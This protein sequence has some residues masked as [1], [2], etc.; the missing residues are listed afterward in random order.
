MK[1][2]IG[3]LTQK[4][5]FIVVFGLYYQLNGFLPH[6]LCYFIDS[7]GKQL[8]HIRLFITSGCSQPDYFFEV[9]QKIL[10]MVAL[11]PAGVCTRMTGWAQWF[12]F[13]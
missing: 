8:S 1:Q 9:E 3:G 13:N 6:F 4:Q 2:Q 5:V 11:A 7:F 12:G 10:T